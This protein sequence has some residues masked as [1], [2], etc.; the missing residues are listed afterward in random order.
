M[1]MQQTTTTTTTSSNR[2]MHCSGGGDDG[3]SLTDLSI[4]I[5][6]QQPFINYEQYS[7]NQNTSSKQS[8]P[9]Y[10][11]TIEHQTTIRTDIS[12]HEQFVPDDELL[13]S[14]VAYA[15]SFEL[16]NSIY[17][18]ENTRQRPITTTSISTEQQKQRRRTQSSTTHLTHLTPIIENNPLPR[19]K[20]CDDLS[21]TCSITSS[22]SKPTTVIP[23][24]E[25][26]KQKNSTKY[27]PS[28]SHP[29]FFFTTKTNHGNNNNNN[30]THTK[31]YR[32]NYDEK[33]NVEGTTTTGGSK[34]EWEF[35]S[36]TMSELNKPTT[37]IFSNYE[38]T[39]N[40]ADINLHYL[41]DLEQISSMAATMDFSREISTS[42]PPP[43]VIIRRKSKDFLLKQQVD[44]QLLRPPTPPPPGPIIIREVRHKHVGPNKPIT[45]H[46]KL[47][48][49]GQVHVSKTP[50][51]IVLRERPP[52][53]PRHEYSSKP[54]IVYRHLPS[55]SPSPPTVI[56]ERLR[57]HVAAVIQKPAPILVEKWLP[58]PPEQKRKIIYECA[59]PINTRDKRQVNE[60]AKQIIVEYDDVNVIVN[61]DIK[62][63]KD[64]KRI[65]PNQ[66]VKQYGQSLY[67]NE[68]LNHILNNASCAAQ[69]CFQKFAFVFYLNSI[70][71]R[72]NVNIQF[73]HISIIMKI[74]HRYFVDYLIVKTRTK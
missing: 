67:S 37:D 44:I 4:F 68:S 73:Y 51:P 20:S 29:Q 47:E 48:D 65:S 66:Y 22:S 14:L 32:H 12:R 54:T 35:S 74:I 42:L 11:T 23:R 59:S 50:S 52:L 38:A 45:V 40:I 7:D 58:Y 19:H 5:Q 34:I 49:T 57:P 21:V 63:R 15:D 25:P 71:S 6:A 55:P 30:N 27:V 36:D 64:V 31:I 16:D 13:Q 53:P 3:G 8:T 28:Q 60:Q 9:F 26:T 72:S 2:N 1:F 56:F 43:P 41:K 18:I 70:Y 46:Q 69:V 61:K 17:S 39:T 33:T 10:D 62:Q 24:E